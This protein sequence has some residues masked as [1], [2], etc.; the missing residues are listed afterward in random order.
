MV[1]GT[2]RIIGTRFA[3]LSRGNTLAAGYVAGQTIIAASSWTDR[4]V[5]ID[6][7]TLIELVETGET[8][9]AGWSTLATVAGTEAARVADGCTLCALSQCV[10]LSVR[11]TGLA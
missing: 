3:L 4:A 5:V 7:D 8:L 6:G 9:Q 1:L 11:I 10:A 2:G